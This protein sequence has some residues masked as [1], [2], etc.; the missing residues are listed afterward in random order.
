MIVFLKKS[1]RVGIVGFPEKNISS[2]AR[3]VKH[4]QYSAGK[5]GLYKNAKNWQLST[6]QN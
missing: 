6:G 2:A 1:R 5:T 4:R 3:G